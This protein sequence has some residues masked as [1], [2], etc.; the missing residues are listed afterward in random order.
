MFA[1]GDANSACRKQATTASSR[2]RLHCG[3]VERF[4]RTQ[5]RQ[6][7]FAHYPQTNAYRQQSPHAVWPPNSDGR[8]FPNN[9][10]NIVYKQL[11]QAYKQKRPPKALRATNA[12]SNTS[13]HIISF[14]QATKA[15]NQSRET[16]YTLHSNNTEI[17]NIALN[18]TNSSAIPTQQATTTLQNKFKPYP[19]AH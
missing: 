11:T 16:R 12:S 15:L 8:Y 4:P 13:L 14:A 6:I 19:R 3:A 2:L 7:K 1:A 9:N 17:I 10:N 18:E 5:H